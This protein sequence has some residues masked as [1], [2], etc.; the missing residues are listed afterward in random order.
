MRADQAETLRALRKKNKTPV[1]AADDFIT[2]KNYPVR[3]GIRMISV[4]SGKGGVGKTNIAANLAYLLAGMN[5]R[6]MVLDADAGLANIDVILGINSPYNLSHVLS[7]EMTLADTLMDGPGGIK[8]LPSASGMPEMTDL[9]R[10]QKLT[11]IDELNGLNKSFDFILID[12]AAG[13]SANVTYFNM[14]AGEIIVVTSPEPTALTDAYALIK[15]LY[16]RYAKRRFRLIINMVHNQGEAKEV[17]NRLSQ[18]TDHFLNLTIE[19]LGHVLLDEKVKE[20]VLQ[21]KAVAEIY[22]ESPAVR[23]LT[24]IAG[25]IC[26]EVPAQGEDGNIKF[27]WKSIIDRNCG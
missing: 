2:K 7:G 27:F 10:G 8:I 22:P 12:T 4:T 23:C 21:Q 24:K 1:T 6:T 25:K 15:V 3:Q 16:Q 5:Q 11:L 18:A 19:Y 17:Y 26:S 14:A 9:S 13:I 20:A